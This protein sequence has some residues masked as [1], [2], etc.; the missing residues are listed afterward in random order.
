[1]RPANP[2]L[3]KMKLYSLVFALTLIPFTALAQPISWHD[4]V[5]P[6]TG[7]VAQI[8]TTV[9]SD[10]G[11]KPE[12]GYGRRFLTADRRASLTVES[13]LNERGG[14]PAAFFAKK[15]PPTNIADR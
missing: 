3:R 1:M 11:G 2:S 8:P 9:F 5:V 7:A 6:E 12:A 13:I 10:D 14:S 15:N 4:Y